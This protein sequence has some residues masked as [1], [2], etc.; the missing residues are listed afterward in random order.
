MLTRYAINQAKKNLT[1]LAEAAAM[2]TQ[3]Y[4]YEKL[5]TVSL[6]EY[7]KVKAQN[8]ALKKQIKKIEEENRLLKMNNVQPW[9]ISQAQ[10]LV[11]EEIETQQWEQREAK[12]LVEEAMKKTPRRSARLAIMAARSSQ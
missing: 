2:V 7:A 12:R 5:N 6:T 11:E 3:Q 4:Q 10:K 1:T 9:E 8:N